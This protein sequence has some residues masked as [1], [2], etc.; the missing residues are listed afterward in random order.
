M[1]TTGS[2]FVVLPKFLLQNPSLTPDSIVLYANLLHFD[3]G[4]GRG[5]FCKRSTLS[6][7]S[8]LS[9]H[10]I[11]N[12]I[13]VLEDNGVISVVR[14]RNSLTDVI[15]ITPDCRPP[16]K[17]SKS[18]RKPVSKSFDTQ[19]VKE[20]DTSTRRDNNTIQ[21]NN[22]C[23]TD[24][25]EEETATTAPAKDYSWSTFVQQVQTNPKQGVDSTPEGT[26]APEPN[27]IYQRATEE[28]LGT[29]E[30]QIEPRTYAV[31]FKDTWI[32]NA[33]ETEVTLKTAKGL[34]V[35]KYLKDNY[36]SQ[37]E[38]ITG[39]QVTIEG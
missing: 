23:P 14:R 36:L 11:R 37:I 38:T 22:T 4:G 3:R 25:S 15:K 35:A 10:K 39:K 33:T 8:N 26:T 16:I 20:V 30:P 32:E 7:F 6:K 9:L 24:T 34:Y 27:P 21:R 5:C 13:K 28:F 2:G 29:L 31:W 12:A 19:E 17:D 1:D 18:I